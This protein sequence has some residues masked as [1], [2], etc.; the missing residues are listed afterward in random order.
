[1]VDLPDTDLAASQARL[2]EIVAEIVIEASVDPD[3]IERVLDALRDLNFA[4]AFPFHGE[5]NRW[6]RGEQQ[7]LLER[8]AVLQVGRVEP[9][10]K[11][12]RHMP[13]RRR[14]GM[15]SWRDRRR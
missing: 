11:G 1:M 2:N 8:L 9:T 4:G 12:R 3:L 14:T 5:S 10:W 7:E 6:R 13:G 15:S